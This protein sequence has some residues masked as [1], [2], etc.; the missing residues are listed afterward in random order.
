[1]RTTT[2]V[3]RSLGQRTRQ[4]VRR[5]PMTLIVIA[6]VAVCAVMYGRIG[7][8]FSLFGLGIAGGECV[9]EELFMLGDET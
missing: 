5:F 3:L 8:A 9:L 1:M 7:A 4:L 6:V 2:P